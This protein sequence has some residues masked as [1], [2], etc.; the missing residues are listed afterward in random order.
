MKMKKNTIERGKERLMR[1][2]KLI[3]EKGA[4]MRWLHDDVWIIPSQSKKGVEYKVSKSSCSCADAKK[5]Y[6]CKHMLAVM[7][8]EN[9]AKELENH[10]LK[11][12]GKKKEEGNGGALKEKE[13]AKKYLQ[14][15]ILKAKRLRKM[16][17]FD[18]Y[19][20]ACGG[21]AYYFADFSPPE[22]FGYRHHNGSCYYNE[23]YD[24]ED[25]FRENLF[26]NAGSIVSS[27]IE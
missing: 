27:T 3:E 8:L 10:A 19:C 17:F 2:Y 22:E 12:V 20:G 13:K 14:A 1:A 6:V 9:G 24:N 4:E 21:S 23:D 18:C 5:G 25:E 26:A 15:R 7:V 16:I 11:E